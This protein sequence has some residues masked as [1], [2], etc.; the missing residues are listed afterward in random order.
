M[1]KE[2]LFILFE[3]NHKKL[4]LR[5]RY[6]EFCYL[7]CISEPFRFPPDFLFVV[8]QKNLWIFVALKKDKTSHTASASPFVKLPIQ[9]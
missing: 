3:P 5:A 4:L 7:K 8:D 9:G 2:I 1:K 6:G